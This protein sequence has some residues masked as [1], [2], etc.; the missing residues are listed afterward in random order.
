MVI[1]SI[2]TNGASSDK[3][4]EFNDTTVF[5]E[6]YYDYSAVQNGLTYDEYAHRWQNRRCL[7]LYLIN[8]ACNRKRSNVGALG[9]KNVS[10]R[11]FVLYTPSVQ[12]EV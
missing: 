12:Y 9:G 6:D 3:S 7:S 11:I 1:V 4:L 2:C 5:T 10:Y 8:K